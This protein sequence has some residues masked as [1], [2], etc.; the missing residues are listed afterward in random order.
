VPGSARSARGW[1][2]PRC[3]QCDSEFVHGGTQPRI[4][5]VAGFGAGMKIEFAH[6]I[7]QLLENADGDPGGD[8][9]GVAQTK[10]VIMECDGVS[11]QGGDGGSAEPFENL[12]QQRP[13][14][15]FADEAHGAEPLLNGYRHRQPEDCGMEVQMSVAVPLRGGASERPETLELGANL[16]LEWPGE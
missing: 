13:R 2:W 5:D 9:A 4:I 8:P 14:T 15:R 11:L 7:G 12:G 6:A 16:V 3:A 10:G 1:R